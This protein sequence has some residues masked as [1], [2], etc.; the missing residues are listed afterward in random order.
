MTRKSSRSSR[1]IENSFSFYSSSSCATSSHFAFKKSDDVINDV[2]QNAHLNFLR[3]DMRTTFDVMLFRKLF[4]CHLI[5]I[6]L[7]DMLIFVTIETLSDY[8]IFNESLAFFN[9]VVD[10]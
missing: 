10:N 3:V 7:R 1:E 5:S 4:T 2:I 6:V 8:A 9:L